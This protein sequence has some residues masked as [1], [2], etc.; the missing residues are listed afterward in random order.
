MTHPPRR[1]VQHPHPEGVHE[2]AIEAKSTQHAGQSAVVLGAV[3]A[4]L[5]E[6]RGR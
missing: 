3:A 5:A 1:V 2:L 6:R 4:P